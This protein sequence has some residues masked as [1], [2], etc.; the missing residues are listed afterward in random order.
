MTYKH[1]YVWEDD[2]DLRNNSEIYTTHK[3]CQGA[4][5]LLEII[6]EVGKDTVFGTVYRVVPATFWEPEDYEPVWEGEF[7]SYDE[8]RRALEELDTKEL[9]WVLES[10][11]RFEEQWALDH[12]E[13]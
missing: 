10:E 13:A 7:L 1:T 6:Q 9:E 5:G 11:R 3:L 4:E 2:K 8:A 12:S